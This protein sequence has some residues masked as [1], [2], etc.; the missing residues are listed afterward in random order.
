[1][2]NG[3]SSYRRFRDEGDESGLVDIIR[4]Y[5]DGLILYL[6][7]IVGNPALA[8]ELAEDT[9]VLLGTKKPRD[10]GNASFKTWLYTIGRNIAIDHLRRRARRREL[11]LETCPDIGAAVETLEAQYLRREQQAYVRRALTRLKPEYRQALW[12]VYYEGFSHRQVAAVMKKREHAVDMLLYR[13]KKALKE[14]LETEGFV[15]EDV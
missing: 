13:A 8:E 5:K 9:F 15:Y 6:N 10:K 11:P 14:Q 4:D 2:E 3:V 12:L 1:M 7:S